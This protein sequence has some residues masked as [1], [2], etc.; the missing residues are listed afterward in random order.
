MAAI[1]QAVVKKPSVSDM[2]NL[3]ADASSLKGF[4]KNRILRILL[5]FFLS[6]I[7]SSIGTFAGSVGII[8]FFSN[9]FGR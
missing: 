7:G 8:T 4:Y 3:Q 5:I 9:L 6:S 1:V 2:E